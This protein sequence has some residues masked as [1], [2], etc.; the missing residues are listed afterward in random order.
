M[1][2]QALRALLVSAGPLLIVGASALFDPEFPRV[3]ILECPLWLS[4]AGVLSVTS[5]IAGLLAVKAPLACRLLGTV[6]VLGFL[7][8]SSTRLLTHPSLALGIMI[9]ASW[10]LSYMWGWW[11]TRDGREGEHT[12]A[13]AAGP[14][15]EARRVAA[16]ANAAATSSVL[17][18]M[19]WFVASALGLAPGLVARL[20]VLASLVIQVGFASAWL[21]AEV[22][23]GWK[24]PW[25]V[26]GAS[27]VSIGASSLAWDSPSAMTGWLMLVPAMTFAVAVVSERLA[28]EGT[29]QAGDKP[30]WEPVFE[31][32][33][34]LLMVTF[35]LLIAAG[36]T[37]L[38][39]PVS[40]GSGTV[41]A[42]DAVFTATSAT[43]VTGLTV[44]DTPRA[45]SF[46]GQAIIALL[47]QCGGLGI[48]T[49]YTAALV[50]LGRRLAMRHEG[51]VLDILGGDDRHELARS[52]RQVLAMTFVIEAAGAL[53]LTTL[54]LLHGETKR[55]SLWQGIFTSISAFCNAGFA[56]ESDN[57]VQYQRDPFVIHTVALLIV[58]GGLG[59]AGIASLPGL[60]RRG[61]VSLQARTVILVTAILLVSGTVFIAIT[62]WTG[63]LGGMGIADRLHNA[64]FQSVTTRTAG[65]NSIGMMEIQPVTAIT[66]MVLMFIGGSPGSTAG[67]IKTTTAALLVIAIKTALVGRPTATLMGRRLPHT[68][69]YKAAAVATLY[70]AAA[71]LATMGL[72]LTQGMP[73][74]T[75]AFEVVSAL[76]TVG[77]SIGGTPLLDDVGK[78][79]IISSM[80]L[81][82]VGPLSLFMLL[83]DQ[84]PQP[85]WSWPEEDL[86]VG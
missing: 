31:H 56:L 6:T 7:G 27:L 39:L 70:A 61:Q 51:A 20:A 45:Y 44:V 28:S 4:V 84:G 85:A 34:R 53:I 59:P 49:F 13:K 19:T 58:A 68:A 66:M 75:A 22:R 73:P 16:K 72:L 81:G 65:F 52:I 77:L 86:N 46:T 37:I 55:D 57:L 67:G 17:A 32:P 40:A 74:L 35:I 78:V 42:I 10:L 29:E 2:K 43:C 83:A 38:G 62:E 24:R 33:A 54:F 30:W 82:R 3:P 69:I 11:T 23:S 9:A 41:R 63:S 15:A 47:I 21:L 36:G 76:G 5:V 48:M 12:G 64:W 79:I 25:V 50:M 80:F 8:I 18:I 14:V 1:R 26:L 60:L 71:V